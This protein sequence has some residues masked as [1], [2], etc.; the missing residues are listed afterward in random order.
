LAFDRRI[1]EADSVDCAYHAA[2]AIKQAVATETMR[3][4]GCAV[5]DERLMSQASAFRRAAG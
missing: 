5:G 1:A 2:I 4:F 3:E